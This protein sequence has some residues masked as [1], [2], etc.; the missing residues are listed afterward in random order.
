SGTVSGMDEDIDNAFPNYAAIGYTEQN[1]PRSADIEKNSAPLATLR[2]PSEQL[3][4]WS[5]QPSR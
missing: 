5:H 1:L 4:K 3:M 2:V